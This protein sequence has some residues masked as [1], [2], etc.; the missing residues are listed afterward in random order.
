MEKSKMKKKILSVLLFGGVALSSYYTYCLLSFNITPVIDG[1][2]IVYHNN[3]PESLAIAATIIY[4][5]VTLPPFFISS[6]KGTQFLGLLMTFSCVV[7]IIFFRQYL[8]SVWCFFAALIS[9]VI[10]WILNDIKKEF[11]LPKLSL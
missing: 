8:T 5:I 2:H 3:F 7:T 4:V 10:Y 11:I 6:V 1:F 9:V